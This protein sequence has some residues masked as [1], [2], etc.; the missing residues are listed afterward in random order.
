[1]DS[2]SQI[3]TVAHVPPAW[4]TGI[5]PFGFFVKRLRINSLHC[6]DGYGVFGISSKYSEDLCRQLIL[7]V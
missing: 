5:S 2:D 3:N 7:S 1:M 4:S 6:R